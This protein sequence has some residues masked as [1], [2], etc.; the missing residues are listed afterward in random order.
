METF[1]RIKKQRPLFEL[2]LKINPLLHRLNHFVFPREF[3]KYVSY[4]ITVSQLAR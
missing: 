4:V 1:C 3:L 2:K